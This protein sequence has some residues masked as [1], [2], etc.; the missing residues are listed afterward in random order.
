LNYGLISLFTVAESYVVSHYV[1]DFHEQ[2]V[3]VALFST[4][5]VVLALALYAMTT[6]TEI[7]YF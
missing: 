1:S 3:V 6:K 5:A 2:T 4:G 7:G